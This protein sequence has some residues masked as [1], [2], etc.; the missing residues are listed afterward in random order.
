[1]AQW[2]AAH[3]LHGGDLLTS[4]VSSSIECYEV[5]DSCQGYV[6]KQSQITRKV[7]LN[8]YRLNINKYCILTSFWF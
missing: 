8:I 7:R 4:H 6:R 5:H 1:M 3:A 2:T